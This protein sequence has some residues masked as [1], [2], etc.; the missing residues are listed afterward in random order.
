VRATRLPF[1]PFAELIFLLENSSNAIELDSFNSSRNRGDFVREIK[2]EQLVEN[3]GATIR[4]LGDSAV[5]AAIATVKKYRFILGAIA[6]VVLVVAVWV[7][8]R[9]MRSSRWRLC[10]YLNCSR[11]FPT[12]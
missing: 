8:V 3:E 1:S 12:P 10:S 6:G 4:E 11:F 2:E 5:R 9:K 7:F